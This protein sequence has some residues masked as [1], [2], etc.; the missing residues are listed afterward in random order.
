LFTLFVKLFAVL[1]LM[2]TS[3][4]WESQ[5]QSPQSAEPTAMPAAKVKAPAM[6]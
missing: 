3:P 2:L 4:P 5:S 6:K 1:L